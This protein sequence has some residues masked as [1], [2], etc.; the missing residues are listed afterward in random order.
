MTTYNLSVKD[1]VSLTHRFEDYK[2][3]RGYEEYGGDY[4]WE[5]FVRDAELLGMEA[6]LSCMEKRISHMNKLMNTHVVYE[7][8]GNFSEIVYESD[9]D[10]CNAY[11][12]SEC[13]LRARREFDELDDEEEYADE[14]Q[15]QYSYFSVEE[16]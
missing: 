10:D 11:V 13:G 16:K 15:L 12:L 7:S 3:S 9:Y 5:D 4:S 14:L 1:F 2:S 8:I 6:T